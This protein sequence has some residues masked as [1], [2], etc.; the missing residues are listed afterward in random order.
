MDFVH[1]LMKSLIS[2]WIMRLAVISIA[3]S[4]AIGVDIDALVS[5]TV[6]AATQKQN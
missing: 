4:A 1:N 2:E 6:I 5:V 3:R